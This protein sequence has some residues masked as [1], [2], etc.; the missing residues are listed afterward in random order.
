M[1]LVVSSPWLQVAVST[2]W[3]LRLCPVMNGCGAGSHCV[4]PSVAVFV[5]SGTLQFL[6]DS[7][8]ARKEAVPCFFLSEKPK[9]YG[10]SWPFFI[11]GNISKV[12]GISSSQNWWE[13]IALLLN[14]SWRD[15]WWLTVCSCQYQLGSS[16]NLVFCW[17]LGRNWCR[18][19]LFGRN[20]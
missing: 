8:Q 17:S 14:L 16:F 4:I 15:L 3:L 6:W 5:L 9:I 20:K 7:F 19:F 10:S 18:C 2:V 1:A 13:F 11:M 12:C